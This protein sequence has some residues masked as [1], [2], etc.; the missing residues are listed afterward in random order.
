MFGADFQKEENIAGQGESVWK[1]LRII[2]I[3]GKESVVVREGGKGGEVGGGD[4][5][6]R[7]SLT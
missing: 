3:D 2:Y 7:A 6:T 5:I 1:G 4:G